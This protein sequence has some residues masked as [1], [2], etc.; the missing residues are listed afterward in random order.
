MAKNPYAKEGFGHLFAPRTT[1]EQEIWDEVKNWLV[2]LRMLEGVPFNY[3]VSSE[4]MLPNESI[5]FFHVDRN[6]LDAMVDGALSVGMLDSRGTL[7]SVSE[8]DDQVQKY[9]ELLDDLDESEVS[10]QEARKQK[11]VEYLGENGVPVEEL[12]AGIPMT[13]FLIRSTV[14]R[15]YP[16]LEV[17]AYYAPFVHK[18]GAWDQKQFRIQTL[19]QVR[20][21]ETILLCLFSGIPTHL[22][23]KEPGEGLRLGLDPHD[24]YQCIYELKYKNE[25]DAKLSKGMLGIRYR[26]NTGDRSVLAIKDILKEP[27]KEVDIPTLPDAKFWG[28]GSATYKTFRV[29]AG[30]YVATQLMQFPYQQDFAYNSLEQQ[31]TTD[32]QTVTVHNQSILSGQSIDQHEGNIIRGGEKDGQG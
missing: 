2:R 17:S 21:S 12:D 3:I 1:A 9:H 13:G 32:E 14:V 16:G 8:E 25:V 22:R 18:R 19:R 10:Y 24:P 28:P 5:R 30:G 29:S 20:L 27:N 15:D 4:E 23:I 11:L 6:W 31:P 7:P 26:S